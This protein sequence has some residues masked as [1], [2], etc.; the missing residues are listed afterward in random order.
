MTRKGKS[1][2]NLMRNQKAAAKRFDLRRAYNR[3][4]YD[5]CNEEDQA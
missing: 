2:K 4:D 3:T 1:R 5:G